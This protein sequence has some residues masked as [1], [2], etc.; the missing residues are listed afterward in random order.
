MA[1][2]IKRKI[3]NIALI[4]A[5]TYGAETWLLTKY[6]KEKLA[7]TQGS[8]DRLMLNNTRKDKIKNEVVRSQRRKWK[9]SSKSAEYERLVG[10]TSCQNELLQS[11]PRKQ[12]NG[13]QERETGQKEGLSGSEETTSKRKPETHGLECH[14]IDKCGRSCGGHLP[15]VGWQAEMNE[16]NIDTYC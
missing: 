4:P 1:L 15:A 12:R 16:W 2:C 14:K 11:G 6:H 3:M 8:M 7:V 9:I 10:R 13:H 5:M